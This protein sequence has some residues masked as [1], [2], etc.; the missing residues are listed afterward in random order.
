[1][2]RLP[3]APGP[4][5]HRIAVGLLATAL[6][7][8]LAPKPSA[9][10]PLERTPSSVVQVVLDYREAP[11][12]ERID[13]ISA[14]WLGQPYQLGPLGEG[15]GAEIDSDPIT[16]YD[17]FDCLTY[18]EEVMALAMSPDPKRAHELRMGMRYSQTP[19]TYENRRHFMLAEWV[20]GTQQDG[21]MRDI[22]S[23]FPDA[24]PRSKTVTLQTWAG[25]KTRKA[26]P[27]SDTRLPVGTMDFHILPLSVSS[28]TLQA[29]PD[30]AVIFTV[31]ALWDHLPIAISH[32]GIKVP[33][34]R[35][36]MRHASRMGQRVV[37]DDDLNWY[38]RHLATYKKWP[39][40]G[41]IVLMPVEFG[42]TPGHLASLNAAQAAQG[43]GEQRQ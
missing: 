5:T 42:P 7:L 17:V 18:V 28:E 11:L 29:I 16:R 41:L 26:F 22:T 33:G 31:R 9:P 35:P 32:V 43:L 30:G 3:K 39:A 15:L 10:H 38:L 25:W 8:G 24:E 23:E 4:L 20:P 37:R 34:D 13:A 40:E 2:R 21:W 12:A 14:I 1:M 36:T 6:L 27:L 19:A